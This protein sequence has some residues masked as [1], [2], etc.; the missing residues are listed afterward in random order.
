M[1]RRNIFSSALFYGA[2]F[3]EMRPFF[4]AYLYVFFLAPTTVH[5]FINLKT[6]NS[7]ILDKYWNNINHHSINLHTQS[8]ILKR[9][10]LTATF[11]NCCIL[12]RMS[13][14]G[15]LIPPLHMILETYSAHCHN[16]YCQFVSATSFIY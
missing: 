4:F 8:I 6:N 3:A 16:F 7:D 15:L 10:T 11:T 14:S 12:W 9:K 13:N 1:C 5:T 2:H